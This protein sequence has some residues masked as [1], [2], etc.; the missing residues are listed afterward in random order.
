MWIYCKFIHIYAAVS[1][2]TVYIYIYTENGTKR[3]QQL[4]F[5]FA[6]GKQKME[7]SLLGRQMINSNRRL[8]F[9]QTCPSMI[10]V[11]WHHSTGHFCEQEKEMGR[12]GFGRL[13][14]SCTEYWT[15]ENTFDVLELYVENM[16]KI[17]T[18]LSHKELLSLNYKS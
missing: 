15:K 12:W 7:V 3:R 9:Q 5:I 10:T 6:N 17:M 18:F 16:Q 11:N 1:I 8:M 2:Y 14:C 13:A 4:S